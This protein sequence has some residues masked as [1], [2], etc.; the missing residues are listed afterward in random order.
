MPY[1]VF[2]IKA[3]TVQLNHYSVR[4]PAYGRLITV[5]LTWTRWCLKSPA[6]RLFTQPLIQPQINE[7]IKAACHCPLW[8]WPVN[9]PLKR[10]VTRTMF[11]FDDVIMVPWNNYAGRAKIY[12][13]LLVWYWH[14]I[15]KIYKWNELFL[16]QN[17]RNGFPGFN[18]T[19]HIHIKSD[20]L[21]PRTTLENDANMRHH[22][23]CYNC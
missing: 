22:P 2:V 17:L 4:D 9:S 1:Y 5:T 16:L 12:S 11:P 7:N 14:W 18:M 8:G 10:S 21:E 13:T 19:K 6:W 15:L 23:L 3:Y 20:I